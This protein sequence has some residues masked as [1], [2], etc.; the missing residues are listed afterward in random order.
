MAKK[1]IIRYIVF[2]GVLALVLYNSVYFRSLSEVT[3]ER[4]LL[5]FLPDSYAKNFWDNELMPNLGNAVDLNFLM[6]ILE[7]EKE[8]AFDNYSNALGIGNIR[9]FF[10]TGQGQIQ[11]INEYNVLLKTID[12]DYEVKIATEFIFGNAVRDASGFIDINEFSN[13]MDFNNISAE[14]NKII[15]GKVV[16]P[17]LLNAGVGDLVTFH[18]AIELNQAH[19]DLDSV[20]VIPVKL[21]IKHN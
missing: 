4:K 16:P 10:V 8:K 18:G 1:K 17:F 14:I 6:N 20:E 3:A 5:Q 21:E 2:F 11:A 9:Y 13:T 7:T 15:R 19:L 12:Q